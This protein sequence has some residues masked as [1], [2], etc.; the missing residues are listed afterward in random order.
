MPALPQYDSALLA[1]LDEQAA[2]MGRVFA[3]RVTRASSRHRAAGGRVPDR[4]GEKSAAAP[5]CSRTAT[6]TIVLRPDLTFRYAG[7]P[8]GARHRSEVL[9][10]RPAFRLQ[11]NEPTLPP[12]LQTVG[13][14]RRRER[15]DADVEVLR[16]A[17]EPC[18]RRG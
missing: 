13:E 1:A 6:A 9:I 5:L 7:V 3:A 2:A 18:A 14:S 10:S 15:D 11:P 16:L 17:V 12:V 8:G 4:S